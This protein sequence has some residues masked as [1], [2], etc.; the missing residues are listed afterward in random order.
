MSLSRRIFITRVGQGAAAVSLAASG[1]FGKNWAYGA[2]KEVQQAGDLWKWDDWEFYYPGKYDAADTKVLADFKAELDKINNRGDINTSDLVA[3]KLKDTPGVG[4]GGPGA[5]KVTYDSMIKMAKQCCLG[6]DP[7]F[8][9]KEYAKKGQFGALTAVPLWIS[10]EIMPA[11]PKSKGIGDYLVVNDLCHTMT[12]HKPIYE[13][14]S[15]TVV[16]DGQYFEDITPAT[17]SYYRTFVM[18]GW[19][20]A[21]NQKGELVAEGASMTNESYRRHKDPAKRNKTGAHAWESPDWWIRKAHMYTDA[22]YDT[23][24]GYWKKELSRGATPLYWDDVKVGDEPT[25]TLTGP[26]VV[27]GELATEL[28]QDVL[29]TKKNILDPNIFSKMA[30]NKQGIYELPESMRTK[31][32]RGGPG[33]GGPPGGDGDQQGGP[34]GGG[35]QQGGP[36]GGDGQQGGGA[37][38]GGQQAG[39]APG[40]G[41]PGGG[42]GAPG[43]AAGAPGGQTGGGIEIVRRGANIFETDINVQ[44][45]DTDG[46]ALF[47]NVM[48]HRWVA[49]MLYNWMGDQGWLQ[50]IH[51]DMMD[52]PPGASPKDV[53]Y[54][55]PKGKTYIPSIPQKS[56]PVLFDKYPYLDKVPYM[57][58]KRAGWHGLSGDAA[59]TKAYVYNKYQKN[60]EHFVD[61]IW[62]I[63]TLDKDLILEGAATVK[64]PKRA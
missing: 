59:I 4:G 15:I 53:N 62:W 16:T 47:W 32:A 31:E 13:G 18:K 6:D 52:V 55:D 28:G 64:L 22:D 2:D 51:R 19:G 43:G 10:F 9:D 20:R 1:L 58:G 26:V 57:K 54:K 7:F 50:Q 37:P 60:N 30:K 36:P 39:G 61:L 33:G 3:G 40:G 25:P 45:K 27:E 34:P 35:D 29:N 14:D 21:F 8:S 56:F 46:R 12:Y 17:G 48:A 11:M 5:G 23:M 44:I 63:E 38:G 49:G 41:A 24:K 42:A